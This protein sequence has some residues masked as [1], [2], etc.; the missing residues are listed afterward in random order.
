M[1]TGPSP[2]PASYMYHSDG[3]A[4]RNPK[5]LTLCEPK[6]LILMLL[7]V[8]AILIRRGV[9][10]KSYC[11]G[12]GFEDDPQLL[13]A[14]LRLSVC[15]HEAARIGAFLCA[16]WIATET[17]SDFVRLWLTSTILPLYHALYGGLNHW[18]MTWPS[19]KSCGS[20][21]G[22]RRIEKPSPG[23]E[24]SAGWKGTF[25]RS[26]SCC[27]AHSSSSAPSPCLCRWV[28]G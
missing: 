20:R 3:A 19:S 26:S 13:Y 23:V 1:F 18:V 21:A 24:K 22:H 4:E 27:A 10:V 14:V 15:H 2:R 8:L 25:A 7:I 5:S 11:D 28:E 9:I 12:D 17:F 6:S 16:L